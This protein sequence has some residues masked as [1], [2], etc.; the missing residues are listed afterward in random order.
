MVKIVLQTWRLSRI[1]PPSVIV[2]TTIKAAL[3]QWRRLSMTTFVL[4]LFPG[5]IILHDLI[6]LLPCIRRRTRLDL[7]SLLEL[8]LMEGGLVVCRME[9]RQQVMSN[10]I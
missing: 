7:A 5:L 3:Y 4:R 9:F 2:V 6:H 10:S 8:S 1:V